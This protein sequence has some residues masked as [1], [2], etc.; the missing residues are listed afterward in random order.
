MLLAVAPTASL[1]RAL[2][3]PGNLT[4]TEKAVEWLRGNHMGAVV[5]RV[6]NWWFGLHAPK[7]GG[8]PGRAIAP[9]DPSRP[10]GSAPATVDHTPRPAD[11]TSPAANPLPNEGVWQPAGP[12]V[13]GVPAMYTT[14]I[15]PDPV[16]T[17]LL[18]G[19]AWMDPKLV[20][21]Q[22]HP[23]LQEPGG[24]WATPSQ[25]PPAER[26]GLLAAFNSGFRMNDASGG[27]YL[28]GREQRPLRDGAA[29]FVIT[30]DGKATVGQ[31]GRDLHMGPDVVAV[32]QNLKLIVDGGRLVPGLDNNTNGA[33]GDTLGNRVLVWRSSVCV[34]R[35]GG[36]IYGYGDGLGALS[37]A[38]MM[39]RAGCVRAMELDINPAWTTFNVYRAA[40]P[41][42]PSSVT[43][44]KLLP[45][46][47]KGGNRYLTDDARDFVAVLARRR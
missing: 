8:V 42:D 30:A 11:L 28:E 40:Q 26:L 38:Q 15:R 13:G 35:N 21:F 3:A 14:Q 29:S 7:S 41:G 9:V 2:R 32:R 27:F 23:G 4:T 39:Q 18:E 45:E 16:H 10:T 17:S 5:N 46:Q 1:A 25:V 43:G 19:L 34:D 37:L 36:I 24:T 22:L 47:H 20:R 44:T 12:L 33:W 31:W 6:E